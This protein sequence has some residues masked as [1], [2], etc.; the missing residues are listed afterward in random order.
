MKT[1]KPLI[2]PYDITITFNFSGITQGDG[3]PTLTPNML[4]DKKVAPLDKALLNDQ[5]RDYKVELKVN[6]LREA[7]TTIA[8]SKKEY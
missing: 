8:K 2:E 1:R 6:N 3:V 7:R 5:I 4:I